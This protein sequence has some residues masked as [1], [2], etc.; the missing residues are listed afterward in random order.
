MKKNG[1][2]EI[3]FIGKQSKKPIPCFSPKFYGSYAECKKWI[4]RTDF[5]RKL[6]YDKDYRTKIVYRIEV[7]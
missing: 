7:W 6:Y 5:L 4:K 1:Y 3:S 2:W